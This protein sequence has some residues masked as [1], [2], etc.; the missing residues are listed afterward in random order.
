MKKIIYFSKWTAHIF[1]LIK[2]YKKSDTI[3]FESVPLII[4]IGV[5]V[6][7]KEY[8]FSE[9]PHIIFSLRS[10]FSMNLY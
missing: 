8:T 9:F 6:V 3:G 10:D 2:K 7:K 1:S 5:F 4:K